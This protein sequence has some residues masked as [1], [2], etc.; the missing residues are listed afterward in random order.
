MSGGYSVVMHGGSH[1]GGRLLPCGAQA[2]GEQA[3]AGLMG[4]VVVVHGL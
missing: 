1:C 3:S 2:T 4:S